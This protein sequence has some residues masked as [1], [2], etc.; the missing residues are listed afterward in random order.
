MITAAEAYQLANPP[1]ED[2]FAE[3]VEKL[4]K[5][6]SVVAKEYHWRGLDTSVDTSIAKQIFKYLRSLGYHVYVNY[7]NDENK[8]S[9]S[10]RW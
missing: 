2:I 1:K 4:D 7:S 8:T 9:L 3:T 10:I 6:I 5:S